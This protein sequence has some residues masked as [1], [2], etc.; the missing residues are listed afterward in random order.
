MF[1]N[2]QNHVAYNLATGEILTTNRANQLK[3]WVARHTANDNA[4]AK[5][6]GEPPI[7]HRWVFVHG[8]NWNDCC[9]K[10]TVKLRAIGEWA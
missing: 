3:R 4:W 9:A 10:L 1:E 2:H 6:N 5:A 7:G 8:A